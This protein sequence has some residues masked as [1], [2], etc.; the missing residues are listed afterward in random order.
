[1]QKCRYFVIAVLTLL[2]AAPRGAWAQTNS[3]EIMALPA[4]KLVEIL[5]NPEAPIFDKAKACQRLAV[6][7]TKDAIPALVALLPDEKLNLYARFGLEG[8]PDPAVDDA[9]REAAGRLQGRQLVGVIN[10]IGQRKDARAV[11]LLKGLLKHSE[12]PVA[13]AAAGALGRIGTPQAA[14]AIREALATD[15]PVKNCLGD[16]ALACA[17]GLAAA[18]KA[19]EAAGLYDAVRAANVARHIRIA[20]LDRKARLVPTGAAETVLAQLRSK[21]RGEFQLGLALAR[22][23]PGDALSAAL[24]G[25]LE[26]LPPDR[27]A[28]LLRAL[29]DRKEPVPMAVLLAATKSP[30]ADVREAAVRVLAKHG[31][32]S[33]VA[34]LLDAALG[35]GE[36]AAAAKEGLKG[37]AGEEVDAAIAARLAQ[38]DVKAKAVLFELVGARRI[39]AA[40]PAVRAALDDPNEPVRLAAVAAMGQLADL[41]DM[42]LLLGRA[43]KGEGAEGTTAQRALRTA[44]LRMGDRDATAAK[45]AEA[46]KQASGPQQ[47]YLLELLGKVSGAKALEIVAA[48]ARSSDPALKD[49]ATRVLGNW[50]NADAAP[51]LLEIA[52]SDPD[53]KYQ[54]RALRGYI[55]IA[56]QLQLPEAK[57]LEMFRTAMEVARRAEEK[58]LALAVLT[59]I[60]SA[61]T[62][63]LAVAHLDQPGLKEAAAQAAV[64]IAPKIVNRN[65]K[66]VAEA[67]QK[68]LD[69][70]P[71][72]ATAARAKQLLDQAKGG[73]K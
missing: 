68:V 34:I 19:G 14:Q 23:I 52:K 65:A 53:A 73:K 31:D 71:A 38:A 46:L 56:R 51:A 39:R 40:V 26:K 57:R 22:D 2:A 62:L 70:G 12:V 35:E 21:D 30:S 28:L 8:I 69:S 60:P 58:Q 72:N 3:K 66:A 27:Q 11:D 1:M 54:I 48:S 63:R 47:E 13:S 16:A 49:A 33:A 36:A 6:V 20:A 42:D 67:M 41:K 24:A 25:E 32:A 59:R 43:L 61:E 18:G 17:E 44:A 29:G 55:R 64:G 4:A 37:L 15:T 50:V 10:S 9:L 5:K 7:G 45:L